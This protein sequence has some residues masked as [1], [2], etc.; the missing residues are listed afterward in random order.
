[1][2][3]RAQIE[4]QIREL[5]RTETQAVRLSN[6][7]FAPDGLFAKLATSDSERRHIADSPLFRESLRRVSELEHAEA[8]AFSRSV[9]NSFG[10]H[11]T[12]SALHKLEVSELPTA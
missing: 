8:S 10:T 9:S 5:V 11:P 1:M 12:G 7:L 4:N 6:L 2:S 3:D